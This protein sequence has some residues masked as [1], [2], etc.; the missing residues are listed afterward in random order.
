LELGLF[1]RVKRVKTTWPQAREALSPAQ[2]AAELARAENRRSL[3][4]VNLKRQAS[5]I[6]RELTALEAGGLFHLSTSMCPAHRQEVLA[7]VREL[8]QDPSQP[9]VRLIS[10]QCVEAGVDLD[11]P[12]VWRAWGPLTAIAQAA[13]RCNRNGNLAEGRM[14]GFRLLKKDPDTGVTSRLYPDD[15]YEQAA[16]AAEIILAKIGPDNMD[17][18]NPDMFR[19]FY[20][21]LYMVKGT[22]N[23]ETKDDLEVA[24]KNRHFPDTARLYRLIKEDVINILTPYD[25][26][27]YGELAQRAREEGLTRAWIGEARPYTVGFFRP[28]RD[29]LLRDALEPIPILG[30]GRPGEMSGDWF[31]CPEEGV[32]D[33]VMGLDPTATPGLLNA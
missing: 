25:R 1:N 15:A 27:A 11:F 17:I 7:R 30:R 18:E 28:R 5:G 23:I 9:P 19:A 24:V 29:S 10:T 8:L 21:Q 31:I 12:V 22:A 4:V 2:T 26:A 6:L 33:P 13:G 32:Y 14:R 20:R 3:C 16:N